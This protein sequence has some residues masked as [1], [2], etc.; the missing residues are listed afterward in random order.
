MD[1]AKFRP[2]SISSVLIRHLHKILAMRMVSCGLL[3][4][5]QRG[6]IKADGTTENVFALS[7]MIAVTRERLN[8]LFVMI[9][10]VRKA[11]DMVSHETIYGA[12]ETKGVPGDYI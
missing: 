11:F 9:L 1:P 10:D 5:R 3:D 8:P 6:F 2:L 7:A 4:E 12:M